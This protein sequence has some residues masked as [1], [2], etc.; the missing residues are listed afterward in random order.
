MRF[1]EER[2]EQWLSMVEHGHSQQEACAEVGVSPATISRW[3]LAG[4]AGRSDEAV[5]FAGRLD[6]VVEGT[7]AVRL[8][9]DDLVRLLEQAAR[10]GSV[11]AIRTLLDRIAAKRAREDQ[12]T[13]LADQFAAI[14][15][16]NAGRH[17]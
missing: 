15:A 16:A 4:R 13:S 5:M 17:N 14:R 9:E 8:T 12:G 6:A 3:R 11:T 2:R 7:C 10:R 1:T